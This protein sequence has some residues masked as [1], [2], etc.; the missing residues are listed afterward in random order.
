M[1]AGAKNARKASEVTS[2]PNGRGAQR[3][4]A[5][6]RTRVHVPFLP[7][8]ERRKTQSITSAK[9]HR[10]RQASMLTKTPVHYCGVVS[11]NAVVSSLVSRPQSVHAALGR[12]VLIPLL[13]QEQWQEQDMPQG[14]SG[15]AAC[16]TFKSSRV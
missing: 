1:Q 8:H 11:V 9:L 4:A 13:A 3:S 14:P 12:H 15:R 6:A 10:Y 16:A 7:T 2:A 5:C